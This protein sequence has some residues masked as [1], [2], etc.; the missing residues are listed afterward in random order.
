MELVGLAIE[1]PVEAVETTSQG[2]LV[3]RTRRRTLFHRRKMPLAGAQGCISLAPR[4]SAMVAA[5][6]EMCP[7]WWGNPVRKFDIALIPTACCDLPVSSDA[8]V[9]EHSGVTWKFVNWSP[10]AAR[11]SMFG[12]SMSDP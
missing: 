3:E 1:E 12:V 11:A 4:I 2:P 8:R 9:G 10:P 6:F 5:W 7:S